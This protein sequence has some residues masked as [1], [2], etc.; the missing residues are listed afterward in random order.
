MSTTVS[1]WPAAVP[2]APDQP[3]RLL[4]RRLPQAT[5]LGMAT[6]HATA[7][8]TTF[9]ELERLFGGHPFH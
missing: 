5:A 9:T 8:A 7:P 3:A 6:I 1:T 4:D 2:T